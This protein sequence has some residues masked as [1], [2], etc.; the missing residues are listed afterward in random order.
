MLRR[1]FILPI[2][3]GFLLV[4]TLAVGVASADEVD[5]E[6]KKIEE[7]IEKKEKQ[8]Q[9][10][11]NQLS[12]VRSKAGSISQ[13]IASLSTQLNITQAEMRA[14]ENDIGEMEQELERIDKSLAESRER[15]QEKI[16][17]R[18]RVIRNYSKRGILNDLEI[19]LAALPGQKLN[20]FQ[21][22]AFS[23]IFEKTLTSETV[24]LIGTINKEISNFEKDR[25]E[26]EDLKNDLEASRQ[27]LIAVTGQLA[28]QRNDQQGVL[29]QLQDQEKNLEGELSKLS[30]DISELTSM[31]QS[32]LAQKAGEG[33]GTVGD[34]AAATQKLPKPGFSP[35]FAVAS[36]GAYTHGNGMS[37][38]GAKGRA[39]AGQ[40]YEKI[41][42]F[43]YQTG[44]K[45]EDGFPKKIKVEGYGE[46]DFQ[47]YLYGLAEM[48]SDWPLDALMAQAIAG[49]T[50]AYR[51][52]KAG[53]TICTTEYCQVFLKSKADKP[54]SRWKEA[55]DSTKDMILSGDTTSQYS[56][57]T[58]GYINNVGW[59]TA[60]KWPGD[61]YEK[62]AGSPWFF[63]A[64]Y[65]QTYN[66][67]SSTCGLSSPWLNKREMVDI[68]NAW[69]VMEKGTSKDT[70]HISPITT[71]CWGGTPYSMDRMAEK[72]EQYGGSYSK[73]RF[74]KV[75]ISN[76][77]YTSNVVFDTNRG[78]LEVDGSEFKKAFNL[79]A[80]GYISIRNKLY[81]II[82]E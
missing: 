2:L 9:S 51:Y 4:T 13:R 23:Y 6:L 26:S 75:D 47:Y 7:K 40:S 72:A 57:T 74:V 78:R 77:G 71:S 38:Y 44:V 58:G 42:K 80:P 48:P 12:D 61:A 67:N 49:R 35:A 19:F 45:K 41:L 66:N 56:S 60:G 55:V 62:K 10:T 28:S 31:Q 22:S 70:E 32:I 24:Q 29:G 65:T 43:Y 18:N 5:D 81:D 64:W 68:L 14:V 8:Y 59:D 34:Y 53:K 50:Y 16:E 82:T 21:Y 63:K 15:L 37:Q 36:Y 30:K 11:T 52:V 33:N 20:G 73:V 1:S 17:L 79:R 3:T 76:S 25:K 69:V 27:E 39:E 54:P 46:L